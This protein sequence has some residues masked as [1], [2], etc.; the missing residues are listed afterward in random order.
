MILGSASALKHKKKKKKKKKKRGKKKKGKKKKKEKR[1]KKKKRGKKKKK[2]R[3]RG[4]QK[5]GRFGGLIRPRLS[6]EGAFVSSGR[7]RRKGTLDLVPMTSGVEHFHVSSETKKFPDDDVRR[8]SGHG[9]S[10]SL[11]L[12]LGRGGNGGNGGG[13]KRETTKKDR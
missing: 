12:S 8:L 13:G 5:R 1:K 11:S 2:N 7:E 4:G 10:L 6:A 9:A 3:R